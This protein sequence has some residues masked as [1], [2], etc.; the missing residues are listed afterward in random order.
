MTTVATSLGGTAASAVHNKMPE[1]LELPMQ[2]RADALAALYTQLSNQ[3]VVHSRI[4]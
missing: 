3:E 2:S 4:M 1:Q